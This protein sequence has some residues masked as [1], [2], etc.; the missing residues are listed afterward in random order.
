MG[1]FGWSVWDLDAVKCPYGHERVECQRVRIRKERPHF[2]CIIHQDEI[3]DARLARRRQQHAERKHDKE[4]IEKYGDPQE[5]KGRGTW[6]IADRDDVMIMFTCGHDV[7]LNRKRSSFS[8][9]YSVHHPFYCYKCD[10]WVHIHEYSSTIKG[11]PS[12]LVYALEVPL[13]SGTVILGSTPLVQQRNNMT[14][15]T[16]RRALIE[17]EAGGTP[18]G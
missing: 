2:Y 6:A 9:Q 11:E 12:F 18:L 14:G 16:E 8:P 15:Y 3:N 7:K 17:A 13:P 4:I 10:D 1:V 5:I